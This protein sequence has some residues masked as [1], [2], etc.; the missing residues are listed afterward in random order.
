MRWSYRPGLY[1]VYT[2]TDNEN[3]I[4]NIA[5]CRIGR[6]QEEDEMISGIDNHT[7]NLAHP[8]IFLSAGTV[9]QI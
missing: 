4:V 1:S 6:M 3:I 5:C 2:E 7:N 8:F 9:G